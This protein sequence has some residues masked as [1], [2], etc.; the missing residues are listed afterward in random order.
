MS[1]R[2]PAGPARTGSSRR[3]R[4]PHPPG[5]IRHRIDRAAAELELLRRELELVDVRMLP[6]LEPAAVLDRADR[7]GV[8]D[9]L[10]LVHAQV[11][12]VVPPGGLHVAAVEVEQVGK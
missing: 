7:L 1:C 3:A 6:F 4:A 8:L 2:C 12:E 10:A 5:T 11:A 9:E